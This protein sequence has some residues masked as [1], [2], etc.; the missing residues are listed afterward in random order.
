MNLNEL[1]Q[2]QRKLEEDIKIAKDELHK[3]N[4]SDIIECRIKDNM[5]KED[6]ADLI[7]KT[8]QWTIDIER[9]NI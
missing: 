9:K 7:Q 6:I 3:Q 5:S 8:I 1:L 2:Q 4:L